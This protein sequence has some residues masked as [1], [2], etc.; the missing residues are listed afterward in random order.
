MVKGNGFAQRVH[1]DAAMLAFRSMAFNFLAEF[2]AKCPIHK[3]DRKTNKDLHWDW[4]FALIL[5]S[6]Y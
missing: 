2:F 6:F 3:S 4:S 1:H 5:C